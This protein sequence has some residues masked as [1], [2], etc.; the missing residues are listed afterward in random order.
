[1][2][3]GVVVAVQQHPDIRRELSSFVERVNAIIVG[4]NDQCPGG[5]LGQQVRDI[6]I[7][8]GGSQDNRIFRRN[9][10]G[11]QFGQR[12]HLFLGPVGDVHGREG[13]DERA[14]FLAPA[15]THQRQDGF[16]LASEMR[17]L[18]PLTY[19]P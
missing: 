2:Q 15:M 16:A 11:L 1:M 14:A 19:P 8:D 6:E 5:N 12:V 18:R 10:L 17:K 3:Q 9:S 7:V 13:R 4:M